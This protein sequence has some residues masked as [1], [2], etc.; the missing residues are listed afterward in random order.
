MAS[1]PT[2]GLYG[3][4]RVERTDG[5]SAAG[6]KHDGCEYFVLDLNH[7]WH[8]IAALRAYADSCERTEPALA[9]DL[10]QSALNLSMERMAYNDPERR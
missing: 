5:K 7:D 8:A 1:N 2:V 10:R 4:F 3:K 6:E 9:R